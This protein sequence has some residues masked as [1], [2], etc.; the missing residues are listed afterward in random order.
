[1]ISKELLSAVL[2]IEIANVKNMIGS[3]LC[4][5]N[6]EHGEVINI[7]ELANKCKEWAK[8]KGYYLLSG[9]YTY[10]DKTDGTYDC[11]INQN[12][13]YE[14]DGCHISRGESCLKSFNGFNTEPEA[15]FEACEW[16]LSQCS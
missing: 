16:I 13:S 4:F 12:F 3:D 2:G 11:L 9:I 10:N 14:D 15:I 1:M 5:N 7:Y 6:K 8:N